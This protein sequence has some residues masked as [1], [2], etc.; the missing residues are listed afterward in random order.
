MTINVTKTFL[1][2][3]EE[4]VDYLEGIWARGQVTNH[5]PL[6]LELE[7]RLQEQLQAKHVIL[8]ANGTIALQIAIKALEIRGAAITTPFSY[9]ATTSSLV[10]EGCHVIF[11]DIDPDSL[12]IAPQAIAAAITPDTRA[13]V[14]TH[15]YG[16]PCDV[17]HIRDIA[18]AHKLSVIY[19]AAHAFGVR[20]QGRSLAAYGDIATLSFHATKLFHSIEGGALVTND[21]ELAHKVR[22][23]RNFGHNGQEAYWGLGINGKLS[24]LHAAMGLAV[25]KHVPALIASRRAASERYD[26]LLAAVPV[27]K[28]AL[29]AGT[30]YN[31][32]YYP[33]LLESEKT[34]LRVKTR[35]NAADIHPRRYFYPSLNSLPYFAGISCPIS[36]DASRKVLCLPLFPGLTSQD[37]ETIVAEIRKAI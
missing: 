26:G 3:M 29:R 20:Y 21:D 33:I 36:E 8:V 4:Y 30:D 18:D 24:E 16:N 28:P 5:G 35:L 15:V 7:Q 23:M 13:I 10:W 12:C 31:Y 25:L 17:E 27:K 19:D 32:A 6:V 37:I 2:P 22:Y 11:A 9:V 14:A 34:L 1:P